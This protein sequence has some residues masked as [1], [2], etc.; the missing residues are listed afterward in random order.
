MP[1]RLV[2]RGVQ[3]AQSLPLHR[4]TL[5]PTR[6]NGGGG[7]DDGADG[8]DATTSSRR[9]RRLLRTDATAGLLHSSTS[10]SSPQPL[11]LHHPPQTPQRSTSVPTPDQS[12]SSTRS[13]ASRLQ[14]RL[15][16]PVLT[17]Q[18]QQQ[19]QQQRQQQQ[20]EDEE[21][22]L[23]LHHHVSTTQA[24]PQFITRKRST[25]TGGGGRISNHRRR[26]YS[27]DFASTTSTTRRRTSSGDEAPSK[28]NFRRRH[29][30]RY[31]NAW[32]TNSQN[33]NTHKHIL[34]LARNDSS[35][36][37]ERIL[38]SKDRKTRRFGNRFSNLRVRHFLQ[39]VVLMGVTSYM[40]YVNVQTIALVQQQITES[41]QLFSSPLWLHHFKIL[42]DQIPLLPDE[43]DRLK[44][45]MNNNLLTTTR[46]QQIAFHQADILKEEMPRI[47]DSL[48]H[49]GQELA[50][51]Q[52]AI[53]RLSR[54]RIVKNFGQGIVQVQLEFDQNNNNGNNNNNNGKDIV[55]IS[56]WR[57]TPY[58]AWA[59]LDQIS[60]RVW[61]GSSLKLSDS[62]S[63][64][65]DTHATTAKNDNNHS[66]N[67][68]RERLQFLEQ[69][70]H[71]MGEW[72]VGLYQAPGLPLQLYIDLPEEV[73]P[74]GNRKRQE[75][76]TSMT[77]VGIVTEGKDVLRRIASRP[78]RRQ[79][80]VT[81]QR[82]TAPRTQPN[83]N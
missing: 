25:A 21:L 16:S 31:T 67:L 43:I 17:Q 70:E 68:D 77:S 76:P 20:D 30:H 83:G 55:T 51:L 40:W 56:L 46:Q 35:K 53:Q 34:P 2:G 74:P 10:S 19:Q 65:V 37:A 26:G 18:Q 79:D 28:S 72:T 42:Q 36:S 81:V 11:P 15:S 50:S 4:P 66:Q 80:A 73:L 33:K 54:Q 64:V 59:W 61:D 29:H 49:Q 57:D 23:P 63:F 27:G 8:G 41:K 52:T 82:V 39:W 9:R 13:V 12:L 1:R 38:E 24:S 44:K 69:S 60:R 45:Y 75:R 32:N 71:P 6:P 14:H 48:D 78:R 58:G 3:R 5:S 47:K 7:D 22:Q 62:S